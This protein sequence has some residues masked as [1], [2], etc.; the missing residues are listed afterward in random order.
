MPTFTA[1]IKL[2]RRYRMVNLFYAVIVAMFLFWGEPDIFDRL[3]AFAIVT[4]EKQVET[5]SIGIDKS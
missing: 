2:M 1:T 5:K 3:R 4:L